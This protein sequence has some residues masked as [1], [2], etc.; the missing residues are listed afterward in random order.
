MRKHGL[1]RVAALGAVIALAAAPAALAAG[2]PGDPGSVGLGIA[3][4][5]GQAANYLP[6]QTGPG[7]H[8][9]S[10]GQDQSSG[11]GKAGGHAVVMYVFKGVYDGSG[12]VDVDHG[13]AHVRKANLVGTT[14]SFD[15]TNATFVAADANGD[16]SR[17]S[18]D[19]ASGD[20]VVVK[21]RLPRTDP[22]DQP[23]AAKQLVDQTHSP[24]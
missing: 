7:A 14:V 8:G 15:L 12:S 2:P 24:A 16:G 13:N 22:G 18:D 10:S 20:R 9:P 23:F 5:H 3:A 6:G 11:H 19:V 4:Q 17:N 1:I 21:A